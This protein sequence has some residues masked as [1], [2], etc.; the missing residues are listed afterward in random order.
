MKR[1]FKHET[2]QFQFEQ[3]GNDFLYLSSI[4]LGLVFFPCM[5]LRSL[6]PSRCSLPRPLNVFFPSS[7]SLFLFL[8]NV[9]VVVVLS[10]Q[11]TPSL[12]LLLCHPSLLSFVSQ[13]I[14]LLF[15][16]P[17]SF[18]SLQPNL[19]L[20]ISLNCW[21]SDSRCACPSLFHVS[22]NSFSFL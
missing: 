12:C 3:K 7:F 9:L 15:S 19:T 4:S 14:H 22:F 10:L 21:Y 8:A 11:P 1:K 13:L 17:L 6:S 5:V 18:K 2:F 20:S 16:V